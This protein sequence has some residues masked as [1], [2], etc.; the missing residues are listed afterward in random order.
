[1][2]RPVCVALATVLLSS[3]VASAGPLP[4]SYYVRVNAPDGFDGVLLGGEKKPAGSDGAS[5]DSYSHFWDTGMGNYGMVRIN[6]ETPTV[7]QTLFSLSPGLEQTVQTLPAG[8]SF[9]P[10]VFQL[11]WGFTP[12]GD[13]SGQVVGT[14]T[15]TISADGLFT[16]GT[17]N[18]L[19]GLDH[20]ESISVNGQAA[21]VRFTGVN[22]E[23]GADIEMTVTPLETTTAPQVPEPGTLVLGGIALVGGV[24][25]WWRRRGRRVG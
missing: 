6:T 9:S 15:G 3:V 20:T 13:G 11:S 14:T 8:K 23:S 1:M 19:I 4:W 2:T 22:R 21:T 7:T 12:W 24:G 17:G 10:G 16:S 5:A 18:Y 25:A